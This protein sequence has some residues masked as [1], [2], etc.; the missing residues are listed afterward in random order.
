MYYLWLGF[1]QIRTAIDHLQLKNMKDALYRVVS[2]CLNSRGART[3]SYDCRGT[4]IVL[5]FLK[6]TYFVLTI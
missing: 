1:E 4:E 5:V 6:G 2:L 3:F